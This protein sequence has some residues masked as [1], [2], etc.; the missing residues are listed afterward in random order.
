VSANTVQQHLKSIFD[1][2][3]VRSR[4]AVFFAHDEPR[5]RDNEHRVAQRKPVHGGPAR[6]V[7]IGE[8]PAEDSPTCQP[9]LRTAYFPLA[10]RT[11]LD[12]H[13]VGQFSSEADAR[14]CTVSLSATQRETAEP[15]HPA[16]V[17][18][19]RPRFADA[20]L[21]ATKTVEL[22]RTR[23]SAP[24]G[25]RLVLYASAPV[26]A[27]VR[28]ATLAATDTDLPERIWRRHRR[29]LGLERDEYDLY[30]DGAR[31]ATAITITDPERL[32]HPHALATVR[33]E[34]GF[35]PPQSYR[36]LTAVD[37]EALRAAVN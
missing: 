28:I 29:N 24:P 27:V 5:F 26:M 8:P 16:L 23:I 32:T 13:A 11:R 35:R 2:T 19:L 33:A 12:T 20:I 1:K 10:R 37:P 9:R 4:R 31:A 22:R 25:T 17:L 7:E 6:R 18:S 14:V 3:G 36:Y 34:T 15:P 30:L 21:D